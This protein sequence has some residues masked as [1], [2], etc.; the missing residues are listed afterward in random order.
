MKKILH[1]AAALACG[2]CLMGTAARAEEGASP[3]LQQPQELRAVY[4]APG[5]DFDPAASEEDCR[6]QLEAAFSQAAEYGMNAVFL[7]V[8][9]ASGA[10]FASEHWPMATGFDQLGCAQQEAAAKELYLYPVFD[11]AFGLQTGG[12]YGPHSALSAAAVQSACQVLA[13]LTAR[14]Q[15]NGVYLAGYY[16]HKDAGSMSLYRAEGASMGYENWVR[17]CVTSLVVNASQAVKGQRGEAVFGLM[18]DPV[19][20]NVASDPAGSATSASFEMLTGG[21]VDLNAIFTWS[22]IDQ[23]LVRCPGSLAD[24]NAAFGTVLSWWAGVA[25]QH[26]ASVAAYIYN[27]KLGGD[28]AGWKAPDQVMRQV[29]QTREI[30]GCGG[31]VFASLP[32]LQENTGGSTDVLLRYYADQ[33]EENDILTDLSVSTPEK[34]TF[35][36]QEPQVN[37][38]GASDP[39]FPLS[40]NGKEL[41]RNG[42]GVF[43]LEMDLAP[44]QNTFAFE[45]KEKTITYNITREVVII[46]EAAPSGSMTVEGGTQ[47]GMTVMAYSGS[48]VTASLGGASVTLT[49]QELA[50]DDADGNTSSYVP[51]KGMLTVPAAGESEQDVGNIAVSAVW[52]GITQSVSAARV[53]VAAL[54]RQAPNVEGQKGNLVQVTAGQARTYPAGVLNNDPYGNC[55]PL[56]KDTVD[57]IVSDKLT[58]DGDYGHGEYY[59]LG[60][61]VRVSAG[62]VTSLGE[63]EWELSSVS[64]TSS[65]ADGQYVYV[66]LARSGRKTAY[67]VEFPGT[68]YSSGGGA[69]GFGAGQMRVVLKDTRLDTGSPELAGNNLLSG[70]SLSQDGNNTVLTLDLRRA[71]A[72]LGYRAYYDGGN[73]VFRFNQIP[74]G[75]SGAKIYID[76]G[77]GGYDGGT[78]IAGMYTEKSMN[79]DLANRVASILRDRGASVQVTDTSGY[80]SLDARVS[81]SQS[82]SPHLFVSLHHNSGVSSASGTEAYYFN[83]YSRLLASNL[84]GRVAGALGTRDR[85]AKYGAYRVTTHMDFPAVL[86][87]CGFLTNPDELS[88][89]QNDD[90]KNAMAAAV[91]D[92]IQNTLS[93]MQ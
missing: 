37:F 49:E 77:H 69:T 36:T 55:F 20:A 42:E 3:A 43:S 71:G 64:G 79:A 39:N 83:P 44:G 51:F 24:E 18:A 45:H 19:W 40:I 92:A 87:E 66:S 78:S 13:A 30:P 12:G 68:G 29:I 26:G 86:V 9:T 89:L 73:L 32:A 10:L 67:T 14:Y 38:Y 93:S 90:Y 88:K 62:D 60:C 2:L 33:I 5:R 65:W 57:Y 81:Q 72:F 16:N 48:A 80:V 8:N 15:P 4:L 11:A 31:A 85:G 70:A 46:K 76:P 17:E 52:S 50:T 82:Y 56:P 47:I 28:E 27:D 21:F 63:A 61:G 58:Y 41:E 35:T 84:S 23:V 7:P 1:F 75:L 74:A 59:I 53:Y 34:R 6:A 22:S 54:P 91:A 25:Q